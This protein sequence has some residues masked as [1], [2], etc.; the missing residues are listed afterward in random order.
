M[1][2]QRTALPH[3]IRTLFIYYLLVPP[4]TLALRMTDPTGGGPGPVSASGPGA[5]AGS[6]SDAGIELRPLVAPLHHRQFSGGRDGGRPASPPPAGGGGGGTA[7]A[8]DPTPHPPPSADA[9]PAGTATPRQ[10]VVNIFISF[11]GAGMLGMPHAFSRSGWALGV[12]CLSSVSALNVHCMLL[13]VSTRKRLEDLGHRGIAGYGDV[14]RIVLGTR[15]ETLVNASLVI[16]QVGFSTAYLI[17]IAANLPSIYEGLSRGIICLGCVPGLA[18]LAQVR[19]MAVLSPF[20]LVADV[21]NLSG[22]A[23]AFLQDFEAYRGGVVGGGESLKAFDFSAFLYVTALSIYSLEGV[24]L[25]LPLESSCLDRGAFP[26]LLARSVA[27]ITAL[28]AAFGVAGYAAF[29]SGTSS[30]VTLNLSGPSASFVK[31]SLCVALYLTY[32]VMLFPVWLVAP[33]GGWGRSALV[34]GTAAVAYSCPDF[35]KFLGLV[36]ASICTLLG[37]VLPSVFHLLVFGGGRF[38]RAGGTRFAPVPP[39]GDDARK[40]GGDGYGD[41]DGDD[42]EWDGDDGEWDREGDRE[43]GRTPTM[44]PWER[45]LDLFLVAFG[46]V[47]GILGTYSSLMDLLG[48]DGGVGVGGG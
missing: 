34:A 40:G 30:P 9:A 26:R 8:A 2:S 48:L 41:G 22:T 13:L 7:A 18:A 24:G 3:P 16:S 12:V 31:L 28:I 6:D 19:D 32:P 27:G 1:T 23:T 14:G 36:G 25:V 44:R 29:G 47:F 42:G 46:V 37:F 45:W 33:A 21:A 17:F 4:R 20:S 5:D 11:V 35:G 43:G 39:S 15:G 38:R 10:M